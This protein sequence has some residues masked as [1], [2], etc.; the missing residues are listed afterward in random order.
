MNTCGRICPKGMT[1]PQNH[2]LMTHWE[3]SASWRIPSGYFRLLAYN[4]GGMKKSTANL[5]TTITEQKHKFY[6]V[7]LSCVYAYIHN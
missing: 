2:H 4:G 7:T 6:K 3:M 1:A 5:L